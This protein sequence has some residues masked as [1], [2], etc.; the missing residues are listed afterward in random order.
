MSRQITLF[1]P[2]NGSEFAS[3]LCC[4]R[5][6]WQEASSGLN[7]WP[8]VVKRFLALGDGVLWPVGTL[9]SDR[10]P[11]TG[12]AFGSNLPVDEY[13]RRVYGLDQKECAAEAA[14]EN[15]IYQSAVLKLYPA[16]N[17]PDPAAREAALEEAETARKAATALLAQGA[18]RREVRQAFW[19]WLY[20]A[21]DN[22][23][24]QPGAAAA[25]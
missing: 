9:A 2:G 1:A 20:L 10:V 5:L 3:Q 16:R 7:Q 17:L 24:N 25:R 23:T 15:E 8:P 13:F 4:Y 22:R 12:Y 18:A 6:V 19:L 14:H 11:E 21:K